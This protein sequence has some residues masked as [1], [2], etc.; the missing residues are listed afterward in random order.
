MLQL[1]DKFSEAVSKSCADCG[2]ET[3]YDGGTYDGEEK[4]ICDSCD[5][6]YAWCQICQSHNHSEGCDPCRHLFWNN[7]RGTWAGAGSDCMELEDCKP[8]FLKML[9]LIGADVAAQIKSGLEVHKYYFQMRGSI[10]RTEEIYCEL[11]DSEGWMCGHY[12]LF[13]N[14]FV[15]EN[16]E[17]AFAARDGVNLL[18]SL[19]SGCSSDGWEPETEEADNTLAGWIQEW[20][21]QKEKS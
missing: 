14:F 18:M 10:F 6:F 15:S 12:D 21:S 20:K 13:Q 4:V 2:C 11:P 3:E 9:D 5:Q 16:E 1:V 19:W 7:D 17:F 8:Q